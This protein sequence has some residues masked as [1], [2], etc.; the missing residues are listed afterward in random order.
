MPCLVNIFGMAVLLWREIKIPVNLGIFRKRKVRGEAGKRDWRRNYDQDGIYKRRINLET[1][2]GKK[3]YRFFFSHTTGEDSIEQAKDFKI[4][5]FQLF[6]IPEKQLITFKNIYTSCRSCMSLAC[7][8]SLGEPIWALL[9]SFSV[10]LVSSIPSGSW[11]LLP[12]LTH[13]FLC[14]KRTDLFEICY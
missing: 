3:K 11:N 1:K 8:V 6:G 9:S 13:G 7:W 12:P 5:L 14:F 4:Y 10:L 2:K